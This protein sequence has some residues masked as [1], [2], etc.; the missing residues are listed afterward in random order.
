MQT[1]FNKKLPTTLVLCQLSHCRVLVVVLPARPHK[2]AK[3]YYQYTSCFSTT[4]LFSRGWRPH[5]M[6]RTWPASNVLSAQPDW[7][8]Q[9]QPDKP[10]WC[11]KSHLRWPTVQHGFLLASS[12][13]GEI[14]H[15][16]PLPP[17]T[18]NEILL[19]R[20]R[21]GLYESIWHALFQHSQRVHW[22]VLTRWLHFIKTPFAVTTEPHHLSCCSADLQ[23]CLQITIF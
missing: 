14:S 3:Q 12:A 17:T 22:F 11:S 7:R 2:W 18:M 15:S 13:P 4:R 10:P 1:W 5:Q 6:I 23:Y 8:T 9:T 19:S 20:G 16:Y 21:T